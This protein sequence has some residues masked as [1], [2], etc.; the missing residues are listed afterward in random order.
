MWSNQKDGRQ[1]SAQRRQQAE[2]AAIAFAVLNNK[3]VLA[4]NDFL[5][6]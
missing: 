2:Q 5:V 6:I 3:L 4:A 1:G